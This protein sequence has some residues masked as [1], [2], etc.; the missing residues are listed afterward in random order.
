MKTAWEEYP[1]LPILVSYPR[2]GVHWI[3][4]MMEVYFDRPRG[5][6]Q[7]GGITWRPQREDE[8]FM[9][10]HTH[11]RGQLVP[12]DRK[13]LFLLRDPIAC[14]YSFLAVEGNRADESTIAREC[15]E[16]SRLFQKWVINDNA[17]DVIRYE[18]IVRDPLQGIAD[19]SRHHSARFDK[20]R[21]AHAVELCTKKAIIDKGSKQPKALA[22]FHSPS[23]LDKHYDD[24]RDVFRIHWL[25]YIKRFIL[26]PE[27]TP[28]LET[29]FTNG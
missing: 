24:S 18:D 2:S 29:Y 26:T 14:I 8:E 25:D 15:H 11:D 28:W 3:Q 6:R 16:F 17:E 7:N 13:C 20:E 12:T 21:A 10:I 22:K 23:L 9:W 27:T 4:A 1:N 19:I 5:P